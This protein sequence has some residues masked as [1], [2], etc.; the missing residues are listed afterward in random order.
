MIRRRFRDLLRDPSGVAAV[1]FGF[2][3]PVMV[4]MFCGLFEV[5]MAII[6]YMKI[7]DVADAVSDLTAQY[8]TVTSTDIDNFFTAG[9]L[10]MQPDSGTGLGLS[11]A[12]VKF[13]PSTGNPAQDWQCTRG[14]STAMTDAAVASTGLGSKGDSVIV[15]QSTYTYVSAIKYLLP[16][17]ITISSRVF[18]RPRLVTSVPLTTAC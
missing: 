6:V 4:L 15:A 8:K 14:G 11:I 12:S 3:L 13:D 18:S 9:K 1:E 7:I 5:A 16:N 17:G 10:V 2:A